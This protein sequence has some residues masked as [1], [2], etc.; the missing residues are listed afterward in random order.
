MYLIDRQVVTPLEKE[1]FKVLGST[2]NVY[3]VTVEQSPSCSCPD[4]RKDNRCKHIVRP[5]TAFLRLVY[6][7]RSCLY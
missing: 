4:S 5:R 3:K 6:P 1:E 7:L 2:G